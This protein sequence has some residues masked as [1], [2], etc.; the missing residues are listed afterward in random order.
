MHQ[1]YSHSNTLQCLQGIL[2]C[3]ISQHCLMQKLFFNAQ[4]VMGKQMINFVVL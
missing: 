4:R 3:K 1:I 2:F